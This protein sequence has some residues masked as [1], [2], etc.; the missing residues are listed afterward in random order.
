MEQ[1]IKI[2]AQMLGNVEISYEG[3]PFTIERNNT[4]KVNQLFQMLLYY[5]NGLAREQIMYNLFHNEE[6]ADPSNSLRALVFRLRKAL[7]KVGLPE[8]DYVHVKR[9]IY[10]INSNIEVECDAI[11]FED[12]AKKALAADTLPE[13]LAALKEACDMYKGDFLPGLSGSDWVITVQ[14]KLKRLYTRCVKQ[15]CEICL[16]EKDYRTI[17]QVAHKANTL[18][19]YDGWQTYEMQALIELGKSKDALKLYEETE[20][21]MFEELGVSIPPEMTKQ[22]EELGAQVKNNTDMISEVKKNLDTSKEDI[23]GAFYCSYPNFVE[24]YRYIKRVIMRSGQAAWLMLCTITDGKGFAL[25]NSDRLNTLADELNEAIR[26]STRGGD[27]YA[28]YS[29]N[30]FVVLLLD[31]TQEDCVL[32]QAR[33]NDNLSKESRKRYIKYNVAPVNLASAGTSEDTAEL[34]NIIQGE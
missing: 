12:V 33:I 11:I 29:N 4:T 13:Q 7:P 9:G 30:Q 2:K 16:V 3:K 26:V 22:L 24:C 32:V 23:E 34:N 31:I 21:L 1:I 8:E 20:N 25:E 15:L 10:K 27:M 19:P 14:V 17:N 6:I 18:Y 5:P 28:R